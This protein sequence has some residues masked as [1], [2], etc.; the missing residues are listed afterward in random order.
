MA[1]DLREQ[2][3]TNIERLRSL[4]YAPYGGAYERSGSL[5]EI[6]EGFREGR[7]VRLAGRLVAK[8]EMGGSLF[9]HLQD[10][11]GRFQIYLK[12]DV[13]GAE[14]FKAFRILDLGDIIGAEGELF[15]TRTGEATLKVAEW[16]LLSKSLRGL[17]EKWHGLHDVETRYRKRYLDLIAN[18]EVMRV[19]ERRSEIVRVLRELLAARGFREVETP[20]MQV[21]AG[22]AQA[23]PFRTHYQALNTD[24]FLRI[25]PELYLK[26]L[27]VGGFD[28]IFE[29]NRNFRNEGLS[30]HHNPEFTM[31]EVYEA[32]SDLAG[33]R[34]LAEKLIV[35]VAERVIGSLK[36]GRE[37]EEAID[38]SPP[39]REV[40]YRDLI[41]EAAG[42]DWY[43][44]DEEGARARAADLGVEVDPAWT[45][46]ELTQEV[47][48]KLVERRLWNPTFV[49]RLPRELV[50]LAK[51]C[52]DD[53]ESADVFELVIGG[54]EIAPSYSELNDPL[55]Q[56][57][58][59]E[60]QAGGEDE[61]IDEDFLE[62]LEY[63]MP[64]AGGMGIGIDRL[65]MILTGM[66]SIRDVILFPHMRPKG[67]RG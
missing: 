35:G 33:M 9:A 11:S 5:A 49:T 4:G 22:G 56:R 50:P 57:R 42:K 61:R 18:P 23:T 59:F 60:E 15:R 37:G 28:R 47:F 26:R 41:R 14:A 27:L 45:R 64:P 16:V 1:S 34:R 55:E 53:P 17:P 29:L 19:F 30:R 13:V 32:Y 51:T 31:L 3:I 48:E 54:M 36:V 39:W 12:R 25:A 38:L 66:E 65:V 8:R 43:K 40:A 20:M 63:G 67:G 58:R 7:R 2:R 46:A 52:A 62:A 24:M 44:L 6:R 21:H 10:G